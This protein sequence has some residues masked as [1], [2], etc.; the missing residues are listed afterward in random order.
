MF[1][2]DF[3]YLICVF[4]IPSIL[5]Y[6]P[7]QSYKQSLTI[8]NDFICNQKWSSPMRRDSKSI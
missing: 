6:S 3:L 7:S 4:K 2:K 1:V 8:I 5:Q